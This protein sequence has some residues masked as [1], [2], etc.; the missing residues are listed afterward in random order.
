VCHAAQPRHL[1]DAVKRAP[2]RPSRGGSKRRSIKKKTGS[3]RA[4]AGFAHQH[5]YLQP[6]EVERIDGSAVA[7]LS[8]GAERVIDLPVVILGFALKPL[9]LNQDE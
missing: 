9:E 8:L 3:Q 5:F 7:A 2:D 4:K 6:R 1:K